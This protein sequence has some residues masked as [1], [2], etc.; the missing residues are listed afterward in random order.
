MIIFKVTKEKKRRECIDLSRRFSKKRWSECLLAIGSSALHTKSDPHKYNAEIICAQTSL[1]K[2]SKVKKEQ[3][4]KLTSLELA[5]RTIRG[6]WNLRLRRCGRGALQWQRPRERWWGSHWSG[7]IEPHRSL[8]L[9]RSRGIICLGRSG[10]SCSRSCNEHD[11]LGLFQS[12]QEAV[13]VLNRLQLLDL[14]WTMPFFEMDT[15]TLEFWFNNLI[16]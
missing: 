13:I 10:S 1:M 5:E 16:L 7:S 8:G 12:P 11:C 9:G 15:W 2:S 6:S 3:E 14:T 4:G